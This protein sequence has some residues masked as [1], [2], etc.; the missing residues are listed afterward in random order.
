MKELFGYNDGKPSNQ[1]YF[2][3]S[4]GGGGA[5]RRQQCHKKAS[6]ELEEPNK[7]LKVLTR[8]RSN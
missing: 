3:A 2:D 5:S 4:A 6:K 7:G 8:P 1:S